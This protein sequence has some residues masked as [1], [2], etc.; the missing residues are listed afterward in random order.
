MT[1][2]IRVPMTCLPRYVCGHDWGR[3]RPVLA[4]HGSRVFFF[5]PGKMG[6]REIYYPSH[7]VLM[8]IKDRDQNYQ[9]LWDGRFSKKKLQE[10]AKIISEFLGIAIEDVLLLERDKTHVFQTG[11][12]NATDQITA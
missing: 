5:W 1:K 3:P 11:D 7:F 10:Y 12:R 9:V 2:H 4:H 6:C 8:D